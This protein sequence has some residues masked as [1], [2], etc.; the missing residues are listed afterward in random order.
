[1]IHSIKVTASL[2]KI[3]DIEAN[4]ITEATELAQEMFEDGEI[5]LDPSNIADVECVEYED[6]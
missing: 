1:M 5:E 2:T 3:L 6:E 4:D